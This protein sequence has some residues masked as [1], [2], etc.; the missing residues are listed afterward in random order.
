MSTW[1]PNLDEGFL[2]FELV[3]SW[4]ETWGFLEDGINVFCIE[5]DMNDRVWQIVFSKDDFNNL[6]HPHALII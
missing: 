6:S 4:N 1:G 2:D 5:W 3:L